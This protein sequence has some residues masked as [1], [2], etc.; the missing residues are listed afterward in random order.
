MAVDLQDPY[1]LHW[2]FWVSRYPIGGPVLPDLSTRKVVRY[3]WMVVD[4]ADH[5]RVVFRSPEH[6]YDDR[7]QCLGSARQAGWLPT[8]YTTIASEELQA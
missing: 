2:V 5:T 6:S 7:A 8:Y 3:H 4:H 1:T